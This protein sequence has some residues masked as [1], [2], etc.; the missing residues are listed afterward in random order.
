MIGDYFRVR[1]CEY[2]TYAKFLEPGIGEVRRILIPR[3]QVTS[4]GEAEDAER[5]GRF[6]VLAS[7]ASLS[8]LP[9][10]P[11]AHLSCTSRPTTP[12]TRGNMALNSSSRSCS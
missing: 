6:P 10:P 12:S 1:T 5:S 2:F 9:A 3:I 8:R 11:L 7:S 4:E